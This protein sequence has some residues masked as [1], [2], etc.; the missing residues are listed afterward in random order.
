VYVAGGTVTLSGDILGLPPGAT[1]SG[2]S[3]NNVAQGGAPSPNGG[4]VWGDGNGGALY[5]AGG[6]ATLTND[7]V[8]SNLADGW[9][10]ALG[11]YTGGIFIASGA[12]VSLDSFTVNNTYGNSTYSEGYGMG[13]NTQIV[14]T[15]TLLS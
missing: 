14:G 12:T 1:Y 2:F 13:G 7:S 15:Y 5:V 3:V 9:D 10:V 4:G 8:I 11:S 6:N